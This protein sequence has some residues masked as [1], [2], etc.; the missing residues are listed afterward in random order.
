MS[1]SAAEW[2]KIA[3]ALR[4]RALVG[5]MSIA[6]V[7]VP[8]ISVATASNAIDKDPLVVIGWHPGEPPQTF[9]WQLFDEDFG[10]DVVI[11]PG[12]KASETLRVVN[13]GPSAAT[14]SGEI[15]VVEH[16]PIPA[17]ELDI[18]EHLQINKKPLNPDIPVEVISDTP[19]PACP[20]TEPDSNKCPSVPVNID[21]E[22]VANPPGNRTPGNTPDGITIS[23]NLKL[24]LKG[25]VG[26][27]EYVDLWEINALP[28]AQRN[29][30]NNARTKLHELAETFIL[31]DIGDE[32]TPVS[33][34]LTGSGKLTPLDWM[35]GF[36][37]ADQANLTA[38]VRNRS[39]DS[40]PLCDW[41][42]ESSEARYRIA[43]PEAGYP[44]YRI[45]QITCDTEL[46]VRHTVSALD[47]QPVP[48]M[49]PIHPN[50]YH[51]GLH[52]FTDAVLG[53]SGNNPE[54][55]DFDCNVHDGHRPAGERSESTLSVLNIHTYAVTAHLNEDDFPHDSWAM[56]VAKHD[57]YD[58]SELP[59][60]FVTNWF[61]HHA[62]LQ[63]TDDDAEDWSDGSDGT[64][65]VLF[66]H[67]AVC[68]SVAQSS[69]LNV[70]T[71]LIDVYGNVLDD[72]E[73]IGEHFKVEMHE[74]TDGDLVHRPL[75]VPNHW[76]ADNDQFIKVRPDAELQVSL[77]SPESGPFAGWVSIEHNNIYTGVPANSFIIEPHHDA[78][79]FAS[80]TDSVFDA[81]N[82]SVLAAWQNAIGTTGAGPTTELATAG[83]PLAIPGTMPGARADAQQTAALAA[84]LKGGVTYQDNCPGTVTILPGTLKP[85]TAH[86]LT[87][88]VVQPGEGQQATPVCGEDVVIANPDDGG[89]QGQ[90]R[91]RADDEAVR[92]DGLGGSPRSWLTRTGADVMLLVGAM[93]LGLVGI[94][95][96]RRHATAVSGCPD[97][98]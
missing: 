97:A 84:S 55:I 43:E 80:A 33:V 54:D 63:C 57:E 34:D 49:E 68:D 17:S 5:L 61:D 8:A 39:F 27:S 90:G 91:G 73:L 50:D 2:Q 24:T 47:V 25:M 20:D 71:I 92:A 22:F 31:A 15:Y 30:P 64:V 7:A 83:L 44:S 51:L 95:Q 53:N 11:V 76:L 72:H 48:G 62:S 29:N 85:E 32:V 60:K 36:T 58:H 82:A 88:V 75:D 87:F 3:A 81:G 52:Y 46:T 66:G 12:D 93:L 14:L 89:G 77:V 98:D 70:R 79:W 74:A 42:N 26:D 40:V 59:N 37:D 41:Q 94:R 19:I 4:R 45:W 56:I 16:S 35:P 1:R 38:M 65:T 13:R 21:F 69:Y 23:I 78:A 18:W 96:L 28:V 86:Q 6:V 9:D 67:R 10:E